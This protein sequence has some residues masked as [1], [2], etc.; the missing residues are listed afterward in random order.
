LLRGAVDILPSSCP[1][2]ESRFTAQTSKIEKSP[3]S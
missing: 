3:V 2:V 1:N